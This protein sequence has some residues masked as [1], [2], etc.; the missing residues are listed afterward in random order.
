MQQPI[1]LVSIEWAQTDDHFAVLV[2]C[3][4]DLTGSEVAGLSGELVS[5]D[6][7]HYVVH[8]VSPHGRSV[9]AGHPFLLLVG[10]PS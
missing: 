5:I 4:R 2:A 9:S 7:S 8:D 10:K 6:G 3:H 1:S